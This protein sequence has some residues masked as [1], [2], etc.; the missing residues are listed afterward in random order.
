MPLVQIP[1]YN[2]FASTRLD[3]LWRFE[4]WCTAG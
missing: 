3:R 2:C 4:W 1:L